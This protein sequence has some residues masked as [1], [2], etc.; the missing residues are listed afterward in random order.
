MSH[1]EH[2]TRHR[3]DR[4]WATA[5]KWACDRE[6]IRRRENGLPELRHAGLADEQCSERQISWNKEART[7]DRIRLARAEALLE[8]VRAELDRAKR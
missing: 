6:R 5:P 3:S 1:I 7:A 4:V 2:S 8:Q